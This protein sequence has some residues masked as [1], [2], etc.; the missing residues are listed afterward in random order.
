MALTIEGPEVFGVS[1]SSLTLAFAV[2][3]GSGPVD[4]EA[5]VALDGEPRAVSAGTAGTRLVRI[6]G[7]APA[8]DYRIDIE[9]A[10]GE[11]R[12]GDAS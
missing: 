12:V 5:R 3:D 9:V 8:T 11:P 2:E 1:E 7:L 10:S 6:E 4:A